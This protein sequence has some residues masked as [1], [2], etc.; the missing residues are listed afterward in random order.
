MI[1]GKI[2]W[3]VLIIFVIYYFNLVVIVGVFLGEWDSGGK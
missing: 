1:L 3:K 2:I